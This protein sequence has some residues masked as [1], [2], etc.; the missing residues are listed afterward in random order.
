MAEKT[1]RDSSPRYYHGGVPGLRPGDYLVPPAEHGGPSLHGYGSVGRRDRVYVT[2]LLED[3]R[4][5]AAG[6]AARGPGGC[7]RSFRR[8]SSSPIPTAPRA[9]P[10]G[11]RRARVWCECSAAVPAPATAGAR[12]FFR[13]AVDIKACREA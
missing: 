2:T 9:A 4:L 6:Y 3:A 13:E 7:T 10:R 12:G 11:R 5:F 8:E 1:Q